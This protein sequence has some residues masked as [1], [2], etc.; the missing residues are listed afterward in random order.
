MKNIAL[1]C[2]LFVVLAGCSSVSDERRLAGEGLAIR[3]DSTKTVALTRPVR[4]VV[5]DDR[6]DKNVTQDPATEDIIEGYMS[7]GLLYAAAPETLPKQKEALA[8]IFSDA[9]AGIVPVSATAEDSIE[10]SVRTLKLDYSLGTW[11][12]LVEYQAKGYVKDR[13]VCDQFCKGKG[14]KLDLHGGASGEKA[15]NEA[16]TRAI[17]QFDFTKCRF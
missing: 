1:F 7:F 12:G 14:F 4:V 10:V 6:E 5:R 17:E 3:S 13:L 9:F 15:L 11:S 16:F 2:A 8:K